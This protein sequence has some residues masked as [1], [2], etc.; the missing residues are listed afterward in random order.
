MT[1][2]TQRVAAQGVLLVLR[3]PTASVRS[4]RPGCA[5]AGTRA[6]ELTRTTPQVEEALVVLRRDGLLLAVGTITESDQ[7]LP[8]V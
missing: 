5:A 2:D 1:R 8:A 3:C 6:I 7:I 4:T